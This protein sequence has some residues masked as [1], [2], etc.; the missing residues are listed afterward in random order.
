MADVEALSISR[1]MHDI[2]DQTV[3]PTPVPWSL[4]AMFSYRLLS[5]LDLRSWPEEYRRGSRS[6]DQ[7]AHAQ[8]QRKTS[9]TPACR[10]MNEQR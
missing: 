6:Q 2:M 1:R 7:I 4:I 3:L 5:A 9:K 10:S 8:R